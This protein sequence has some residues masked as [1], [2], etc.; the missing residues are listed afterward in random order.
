MEFSPDG[1]ILVVAG[2]SSGSVTAMSVGQGGVVKES[3]TLLHDHALVTP[4]TVVVAPETSL[5]VEEEE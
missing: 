1:D 5:E 4:T 2:Q 3:H